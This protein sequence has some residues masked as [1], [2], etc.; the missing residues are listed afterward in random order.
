MKY[1]KIL[2]EITQD[3]LLHHE[4]D[5]ISR[6]VIS[7]NLDLDAETY[8]LRKRRRMLRQAKNDAR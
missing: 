3:W 2:E 1:A 8:L 4:R 6:F 7:R 5:D